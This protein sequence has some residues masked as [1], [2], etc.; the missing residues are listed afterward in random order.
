MKI[1]DIQTFFFLWYLKVKSGRFLFDNKLVYM[2]YFMKIILTFKSNEE[3][4]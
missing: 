3:E 4:E 2:L 1:R